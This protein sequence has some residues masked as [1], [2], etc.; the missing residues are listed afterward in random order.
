MHICSNICV[1]SSLLG[2]LLDHLRFCQQDKKESE[3]GKKKQ[4][5]EG[6]HSPGWRQVGRPKRLSLADPHK[7]SS[8]LTPKGTRFVSPSEYS[9][10]EMQLVFAA[11]IVNLGAL[12]AELSINVQA[13]RAESAYPGEELGAELSEDRTD[14]AYKAQDMTRL[15]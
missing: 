15:S 3:R 2:M 13:L 11:G 4:R 7:S 10:L 12:S 14:C 9:W 1:P 5:T 8:D 6:R